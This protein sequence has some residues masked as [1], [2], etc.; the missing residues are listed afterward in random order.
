MIPNYGYEKGLWQGEGPTYSITK[1]SASLYTYIFT[2]IK[3]KDIKYDKYAS[4]IEDK[5]A[6]VD[7]IEYGKKIKR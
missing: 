3:N 6:A 2:K 7:S 4:T 1:D 5:K